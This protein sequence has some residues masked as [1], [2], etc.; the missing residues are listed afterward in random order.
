MKEKQTTVY[1]LTLN[2][3]ALDVWKWFDDHNLNDPVM[4]MVKVQEEIGELAHE[5]SRN[6]YDTPEVVD[7]LGDSL[8]TLIGMCHHLNIEPAYALY[9]AYNEIKDRKGTVIKG[10]FVKEE[11]GE[12]KS[13]SAEGRAGE[14]L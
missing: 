12:T 1:D 2:K 9:T 11:N 10:S 14:T 3:I 7:A 5:I 13:S 6:R 4:Q 8:V